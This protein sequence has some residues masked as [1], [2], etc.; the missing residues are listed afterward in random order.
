MDKQ[1]KVSEDFVDNIIWGDSDPGQDR[2]ET[3]RLLTNF[4]S[5]WGDF[6]AGGELKDNVTQIFWHI[7]DLQRR[8][9]RRKNVKLSFAA[10]RRKYTEADPVRRHSIDGGQYIVTE[11]REDI[12]ADR[13]Y[14]RDGRDL[15][16]IRDRELAHY[17]LLG[18][19]E[20]GGGVVVCPACGMPAARESLLNGCDACGTK[21]TV[22]DLGQRVAGFSLRHD[23]ELQK[24][25]L[26]RS[27]NR[28]GNMAGTVITAVIAVLYCLIMAFVG[29]LLVLTAGWT[30]AIA[31]GMVILAVLVFFALPLLGDYIRQGLGPM[32][33]Y[34]KLL[35][36]GTAETE[37]RTGKQESSDR[38]KEGEIRKADPL[39]SIEVFY[40]GLEN[41]LA[42]VVYADNTTVMNAFAAPGTDLS[43]LRDECRDYIYL[44]MTDA[45]LDR[46][47]YIGGKRTVTA[48]GRLKLIKADD[49]GVKKMERFFEVVL[50]KD[51]KCLTAEIFSPSVMHCQGCGASVSLL[52]GRFCQ[53]C[54]TEIDL[55]KYDWAIKELKIYRDKFRM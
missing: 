52:D 1:T 50:E 28:L 53:Y 44:E 17:T 12:A 2:D 51:E 30:A 49:F 35:I 32:K 22:N 33:F 37:G 9:L 4:K 21:F 5:E 47:E 25:Q 16:R 38:Q 13:V 39:F 6:F 40:T 11:I 41:K 48:G 19:K 14:S 15:M 20:E 31:G 27:V 23:E 46:H 55:E 26:E 45:H 18:A 8:R 7:A 10:E 3:E 54:G 42:S 34:G 36:A 43:S 24:Q 29:P